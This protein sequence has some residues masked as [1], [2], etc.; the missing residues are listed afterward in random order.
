MLC[1]VAQLLQEEGKQR[2]HA[3]AVLY[4]CRL[5]LHGFLSEHSRSMGSGMSHR[6]RNPSVAPPGTASSMGCVSNA[7][8]SAGILDALLAD[9]DEVE[10]HDMHV[11]PD[12]LGMLSHERCDGSSEL[13]QLGLDAEA[14]DLRSDVAPSRPG[15]SRASL[16]AH[17][18]QRGR[19]AQRA[20][21]GQ[22]HV[23]TMRLQPH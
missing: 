6:S 2:R 1:S 17:Y 8:H 15:S 13:L 19:D 11:L 18:V 9:A 10:M 4:T 22:C 3:K 14:A 12:G 7:S 23:P 16:V 21:S 5:A 20:A